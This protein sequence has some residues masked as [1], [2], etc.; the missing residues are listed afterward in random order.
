MI[1]INLAPPS[2]KKARRAVSA[3]RASTWACCSAGSS[4]SSSLVLGGWWWSVSAEIARLNAEIA[5]TSGESSSAQGGHR[6]GPALPAGE[7]GARAA[8]STPSRPW[9]ATRRGPSTCSTPWPTPC[10]PTSGSPGSRRRGTQLRLAGT[11]YSSR[12]PVRLHGQSQ[13][14]GQVQGRGPRG[15]QAGPHQVAAHDHLR[16]DRAGSRSEPWRSSTRSPT[17]PSPRRSRWA[18]SALVIVAALGY[19]LLVSPKQHRSATPSSQENEVRRPRCARRR[20]TRPASAAFRAQAEALRKRLEAAKERLPSE[21]EMPGLYRQVSDLALPV[22]PGRGAL[23][24]QAA[25]G[26]G[27]RLPRCRSR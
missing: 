24:A 6:R 13:G 1:R 26:Q 3:R 9:P 15:R 19:F 12:R 27:R 14:L 23:R 4:S 11:T 5:R 25:R 8:A 7:G 16:G 10:P 21:R 20:P 18:S 17:L 2:T 22:G